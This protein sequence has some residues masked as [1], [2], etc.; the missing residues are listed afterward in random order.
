MFEIQRQFPDIKLL[1]SH[2][3]LLYEDKLSV[4]HENSE[5][6][7]T[8]IFFTDLIL[9]YENEFVKVIQF[10]ENSYVTLPPNKRF[11][12]NLLKVISLNMVTTFI[13]ES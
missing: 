2:R 11:F 4:L 12:S 5:K 7:V 13:F 3:K 6:V 9:L 8:S 1:D 10:N